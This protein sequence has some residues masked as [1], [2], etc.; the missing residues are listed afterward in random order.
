VRLE[1]IDSGA[2]RALRFGKIEG[3]V[4]KRGGNSLSNYA[5]ANSPVSGNI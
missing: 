1:R 5:S 2:K 4:S 3:I